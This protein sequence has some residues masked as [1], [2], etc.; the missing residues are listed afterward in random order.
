[1]QALEQNVTVIP[2]RKR[3]GSQRTACHPADADDCGVRR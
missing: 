1:M 3:V 2:A